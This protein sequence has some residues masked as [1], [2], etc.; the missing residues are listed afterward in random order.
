M[1]AQMP[2]GDA[3]LRVVEQGQRTRMG[4]EAVTMRVEMARSGQ[5]LAYSLVV[6][7]GTALAEGLRVVR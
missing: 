6:V 2:K 7:P 5:K 3:N 4:A 1:L